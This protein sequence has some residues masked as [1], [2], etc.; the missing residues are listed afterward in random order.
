MPTINNYKFNIMEKVWSNAKNKR[1]LKKLYLSII[2]EIRIIAKQCGYAIGVHGSLTRDLDLIAVPWVN[3]YVKAETLAIR[4]HNGICKYSFG[5]KELRGQGDGN[6]PHGRVAYSL[7]IGF[8]G[9]YIDL[10][11]VT[12]NHKF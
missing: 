4:I 2:P 6:K 8:H 3:K 11:I 5:L 12:I 9:A 10:S 1:E 7:P